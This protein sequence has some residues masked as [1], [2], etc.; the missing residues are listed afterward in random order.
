LVVAVVA[1]HQAQRMLPVVV[2]VQV[3]SSNPPKF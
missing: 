3:V 1:Q 2:V